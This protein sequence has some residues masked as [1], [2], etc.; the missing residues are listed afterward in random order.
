MFASPADSN[1]MSGTAYSKRTMQTHRIAHVDPLRGIALDELAAD[2]VVQAVLVV[3]ERVALELVPSS[4]N[5]MLVVS[6]LRPQLLVFGHDVDSLLGH[7]KAARIREDLE[8][9]TSLC[10]G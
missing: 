10:F 5:G 2:E 6:K 8:D 7:V 1:D 9:R 3:E 4:C